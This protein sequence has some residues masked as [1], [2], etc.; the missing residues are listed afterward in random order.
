MF[1]LKRTV[2]CFSG[3]YL[4]ADLLVQRNWPVAEGNSIAEAGQ[5]FD[6]LL[7]QIHDDK[8]ALGI[9]MKEQRANGKVAALDRQAP[10]GFVVTPV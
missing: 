6:R 7:G 8:G 5:P 10:L 4:E 9:W 1:D 3:K 2:V